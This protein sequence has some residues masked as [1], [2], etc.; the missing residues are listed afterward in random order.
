MEPM[1][2][3]LMEE[4]YGAVFQ[5]PPEIVDVYSRI[6]LTIVAAD[7]IISPEEWRYVNAYARAMGVPAEISS[8]WP[9]TDFSKT[10]LD[11]DVRSFWRLIGTP[12]YAFIYDAIKIA[13]ADGFAPEERAAVMRAVKAVGIP[14]HLVNQV[15]KLLELERT[16][17]AMRVAL[18]YPEP[19]LF[20]DPTKFHTAS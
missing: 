3:F 9:K 18:L 17:R 2:E 4:T 7:G 16:A 19:T 5:F 12:N 1:H 20:H 11:E 6:V 13:S 14:T 8:R 10:N 15:E